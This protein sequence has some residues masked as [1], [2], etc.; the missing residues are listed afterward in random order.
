MKFTECQKR[1]GS[2]RTQVRHAKGIAS[3]A[4]CKQSAPDNSFDQRMLLGPIVLLSR[5]SSFD[6]PFYV[7]RGPIYRPQSGTSECDAEVNSSVLLVNEG[8]CD[9]WRFSVIVPR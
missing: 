8:Y 4:G 2:A 6:D 3:E 5:I 9:G 7:P 1:N